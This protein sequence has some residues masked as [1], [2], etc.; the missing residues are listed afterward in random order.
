MKTKTYFF[1]I[2]LMCGCSGKN[3]GKVAEESTTASNVKLEQTEEIMKFQHKNEDDGY[4][5]YE[6]KKGNC[7]G[8]R[9]S[10][11]NNIIPIL[12]DNVKYFCIVE[13]GLHY[14]EVERGNNKG[15]YTRK[16]SLV[17]SPNKHYTEIESEIAGGCLIWR[18]KKQGDSKY[19]ILDA[20][21]NEVF[22]IDCKTIYLQLSYDDY[23]HIH[24]GEGNYTDIP[25][26]CVIKDQKVGICGLDGSIVCPPEYDGCYL[27]DYGKTILIYK[28]AGDDP[29]CISTNYVV[30]NRS[31]YSPYEDLY[32]ED[33]LTE[34][35]MSSSSSSNSSTTT[36]NISNDN[37]NSETKTIVVEHHRDPVPVTEWVPCG[38][39]GFNPGVCQTC[40]GMGE[41]ASGRR[42]IS[43][44]GTGR[45]HF[46]NG[47]G[48]RYQTV[49]R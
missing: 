41:S 2:I 47:Q 48:G 39:C 12:F 14:F 26:F 23:D 40:V 10:E 27:K 19:Y 33:Y 35:Q 5:W 11:G 21:G 4:I 36:Q 29:E 30:K 38:A 16:G 22:S 37:S 46:C 18:A 15:I 17:V 9:D 43:C 7:F 24:G 13:E 3:G 42:C 20:K 28:N 1:F 45:C 44:R 6:L 32:N 49:Y 8:A 31:R 25:Y 34:K